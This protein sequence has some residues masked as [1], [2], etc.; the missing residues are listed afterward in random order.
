[1]FSQVNNS[2]NKQNRRNSL[3]SLNKVNKKTKEFKI[4]LPIL[5]MPA[6][7]SKLV[8]SFLFLTIFTLLLSGCNAFNPKNGSLEG[9]VHRETSYSTA[10]L[11]GALISISGSTNT[12][13]TD[14]KGYFLLSDIS[15]GR[16]ALT[17]IKE[18]YIT[19]KLLNVYIEPDII[20]EVYFGEPIILKPKEDTILYN[21]AIDYLN[22]KY[23]QQALDTFI[24]LR[25]TFPDSTWADDAQ[26]YIGRVNE[27]IGDY[28]EARDGYLALLEK[29]PNSPWAANAY[30]GIGNC[31]YNI[32]NYNNAKTQYQTVIE[33]YP[34]NDLIPFA[35]YRIAWCDRRLD[36]HEGALQGFQ[37]VIDLYPQSSYTPPSQ[38]FIGEIYYDLKDYN[39]AIDA[40][41]ETIN[42]YPLATWPDEK[43]L[44]APAAYFYIGYCYEQQEMWQYAIDN[45]EVVIAQYP[46]ST[47]EDGKSIVQQ[48][49]NRIDYIHEH[50]LPPEEEDS[51]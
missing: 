45:Y 18:G 21:K 24:E 47:W 32:G 34:F 40:F 10:P 42:N 50:Y 31:Y 22:Q 25:D 16:R 8:L 37:N 20:N 33:S 38:Y 4:K 36:D 9:E 28:F 43:R 13:T 15:V 3:N 44:I 29:Y 14:Q 51:E 7:S 39:K 23:Y 11:E 12:T 46:G 27:I 41:Q 30:L 5:A 6:I 48:A 19:L 2:S 17:I 26:Y 35:Q 1:M 49:Q